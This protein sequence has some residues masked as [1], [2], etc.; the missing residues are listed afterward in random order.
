MT[1]LKIL[2]KSIDKMKLLLSILI[3][4]KISVFV[5][6][7]ETIIDGENMSEIKSELLKLADSSRRLIA[8][9]L[10]VFLYDY[11]LSKR[12]KHIP[13]PFKKNDE[14][15]LKLMKLYDDVFKDGEPYSKETINKLGELKQ[16]IIAIRNDVISQIPE[17]SPLKADL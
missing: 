1:S 5:S 7:E 2:L 17:S 12:S 4:D 14:L 15:K 8:G 11:D 13:F 10:N 6:D 3:G 16:A 9:S